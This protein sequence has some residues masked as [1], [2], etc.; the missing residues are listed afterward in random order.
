M[1]PTELVELVEELEAAEMVVQ[2]EESEAAGQF[3]LVVG[4]EAAAWEA[5]YCKDR[6]LSCHDLHFPSRC[7]EWQLSLSGLYHGNNLA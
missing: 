7:I 6:T 4:P 3:E 5:I 1:G 2:V